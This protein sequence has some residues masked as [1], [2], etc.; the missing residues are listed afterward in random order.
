MTKQYFRPT[1]D[2]GRHELLG[3]VWQCGCM[4]MKKLHGVQ[5]PKAAALHVAAAAISVVLLVGAIGCGNGETATE[6]NG[7]GDTTDAPET[8]VQF[9]NVADQLGFTMPQSIKR[10]AP[11]CLFQRVSSGPTGCEAERMTGGVAVGDYDGDG[12][13]DLLFTNLDGPPQLHRNNGDGTFSNMTEASGLGDFSVRS[14]G[15]AWADVDNDGNLDLMVTTMA[16][17]RYYLFINNGDGTFTEDA[18]AR[19]AALEYGELRAGTSVT[20]GDFDN[21]GWIDMHL[22][23]WVPRRA[24]G[25]NAVS[26]AR[27]LRNLGPS[28]PGSFEDVTESAGVTLGL[29]V[30]DSVGTFQTYPPVYSFASAITDLDGDG[31]ADLIVASD[32]GTTQLFW[33]NGDGTFTEGTVPSRIGSEGHGMGLAIGDINGDGLPDIFITS[34]SNVARSCDGR[35]CDPTLTGNRLYINNGDRTFYEDND[36]AEVTTGFWGWGAAMPDIDND[37]LLDIVMANGVDLDGDEA[38]LAA[39]GEFR[40][41]PKRLWLNTPSGV[42]D[43]IAVKSGIDVLEPATG[44]AVADLFGTGHLDIIMVHPGRSPSVWKNS[45]TTANNWIRVK[46]VGTTSNRD[47]IGAVITITAESSGPRQTRTVGANSYFLGHSERTV[48]FGLGPSSTSVSDITVTFPATG[49]EVV[50]RNVPAN[51]TIIVTEPES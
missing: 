4:A 43:E 36:R 1:N 48:H 28:S 33:N 39:N 38:Y 40:L 22:T 42:F 2:R 49:R 21:D 50:L 37:G 24:Q 31:W 14:N 29:T 16:S 15:A 3:V 46:A 32:Y 27:L 17:D 47:A 41:N 19:G 20:F 44:L 6:L 34:I 9:T 45:A 12:L 26:H 11:E 10:L 8:P 23:E 35:P 7:Q 51:Q 30:T 5:R 13:D 25:T 18:V